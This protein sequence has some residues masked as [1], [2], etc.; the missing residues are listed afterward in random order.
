MGVASCCC[1]CCCTS[2]PPLTLQLSGLSPLSWFDVYFGKPT[3]APHR[4]G[5]DGSDWHGCQGRALMLSPQGKV[6]G[7]AD[8]SGSALVTISAIGAFD[9]CH[10]LVFEVLEAK[11]CANSR[12]GHVSTAF[13]SVVGTPAQRWKPPP[14]ASRPPPPPP[15]GYVV[16]GPPSAHAA[17]TYYIPSWRSL[18][19]REGM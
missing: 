14:P 2:C 10:S 4:V 5:S 15:R 13:S 3:D 7:Q 16:C 19:P 17:R 12:V 18:M 11:S 9:A 6:A 1:C 8:D